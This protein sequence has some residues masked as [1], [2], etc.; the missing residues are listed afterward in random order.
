MLEGK[1]PRQLSG[2]FPAA[3]SALEAVETPAKLPYCSMFTDIRLMKSWKKETVADD[4]PLVG[5]LGGK[6]DKGASD[7]SQSRALPGDR[8]LVVIVG[9]PVLRV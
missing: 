2:T 7:L 4:E 5:P 1:A 3:I 6:T 8:S 9:V